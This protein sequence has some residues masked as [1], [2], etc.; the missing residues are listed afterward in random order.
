MSP[1]KIL[2]GVLEHPATMAIAIKTT[3]VVKP[4][5]S[6]VAQL[7]SRGLTLH[8]KRK[9]THHIP[10]LP[11]RLPRLAS[12]PP[13]LLGLLAAPTQSKTLK[14]DEEARAWLKD[15][16][17]YLKTSRPTAVNLFNDCDRLDLSLYLD[18]TPLIPHPTAYLLRPT[19]RPNLAAN[20]SS[21]RARQGLK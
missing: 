10:L 21:P 20:L 8:L 11:Q 19:T 15:R 12:S 7:T 9:P 16:L 1:L 18:P 5:I 6:R 13:R 14:T 3:S 17:E 2:R 4:P